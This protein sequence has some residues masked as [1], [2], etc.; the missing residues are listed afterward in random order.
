MQHVEL[1]TAT[2]KLRSVIRD[3]V[4]IFRGI[5]YG[6]RATPNRRYSELR[7]PFRAGNGPVRVFPQLPNRLTQVMGDVLN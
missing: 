6:E 2:G 3:G 5:R 1:V 7:D 4:R